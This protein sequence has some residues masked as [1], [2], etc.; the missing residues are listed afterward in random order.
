M[1]SR[2]RLA[3]ALR[4]LCRLLLCL[5]VLGWTRAAPCQWPAE[6]GCFWGGRELGGWRVLGASGPKPGPWR[7]WG[8]MAGVLGV[9]LEFLGA[10]RVLEQ[11]QACWTM[12]CRDS[13]DPPYVFFLMAFAHKAVDAAETC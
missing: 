4:G 8:G 3:C 5:A 11:R 6:T 10:R 12:G 7:G 13:W 9:V 1:L 2:H